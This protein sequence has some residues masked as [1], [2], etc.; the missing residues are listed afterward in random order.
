MKKIKIFVMDV[1]GTITDGKIYMAASGELFKAFN[2][3]D[4]YGI[5]ELLPQYHVKT[6]IITGRKS[7]IVLRRAKELE[8]NFVLQ[9]IKNKENALYEIA[10]KYQCA[11]SEIAYIGDDLIDLKPMQLCG[12]AG[13]PFDAVSEIKKVANYVAEARGGFGAVREFIDWLIQ[14]KYI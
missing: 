4:G 8:I 14:K 9:N 12:V 11:L 5:H 2:I 6:V 1:D 3:K 10:D 13:C 7:E